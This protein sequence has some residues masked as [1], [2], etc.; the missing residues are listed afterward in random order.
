MRSPLFCSAAGRAELEANTAAA[1]PMSARDW[2]ITGKRAMKGWRFVYI[3]YNDA[4]DVASVA[5]FGIIYV[6][7]RLKNRR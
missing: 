1:D 4:G 7:Q 3:A 2:T 5:D 6:R